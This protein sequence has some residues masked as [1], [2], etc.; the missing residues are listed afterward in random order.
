MFKDELLELLNINKQ[1]IWIKTQLEKEI[2][3][4][5]INVL[6]EYGTDRIFT[7]TPQT[8]IEEIIT[9]DNYYVKNKLAKD[10][11]N[12]PLNYF[13]NQVLENKNAIDFPYEDDYAIIIK[14][15][16]LI[17]ETK[18]H[19]R[20]LKEI[21]EIHQDKYIPLIFTSD[22]Y[23][24]PSKINHLFSVIN[25]QTPTQEEILKLLN[26]YENIKKRTIDNKDV[27]SKKLT[28]F[29]RDEI[30][31]LINLSFYRY[32]RIN[33]DILNDKK[34]ELINKTNVIDY[35]TPKLTLDDIGGNKNFKRWFEEIKLCMDDEATKYGVE[36]PKG[37]LA[38]G[39]AGCSKSALA[40]AIANDLNIP[41][42]KLNMSK[43]LSKF[44][45]DSERRIEQATNLIKSCAPCVLLIDEVEK[46]L[47]GYQS[48]NASDSGT[49]SRVFNKVLDLLVENDNGIF[50]IMTSNN[51]RDLPPELTRAGRLDAIFYFSLPN[52]EE[53]EEIFKIHFKKRNQNISE[54]I[55]KFIAKET[56]N[57]TGAEIEQIVKSSIKKAYANKIKNN[58]EF[59]ITKDI[60]LKA[61]EDVIPISKSSRE[62]IFALEDY[63]NGRAL[64]SNKK[65]K[66]I[67]ID[68]INIDDIE[69]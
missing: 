9:K 40:E 63:A 46:A 16:D 37:Y 14:D 68:S 60:L 1:C 19:I 59:K 41:F 57:Y 8:G 24:P 11:S 52:K 20:I 34:I 33:L 2:M 56:N 47:G 55:I 64:Y 61:K 5:I 42:L 27:V 23:D 17:Y 13:Y 6:I 62:K 39:I 18:E 54:D 65:D 51:V 3:I 21:T 49:L 26:T 53:R 28:G 30:I 48:S 67:D 36:K 25:Y 7:Y 38:L 45:G 50:T 69:I 43:I 15:F 10:I 22:I 31:E 58:E 32:N 66:S 12:R 44:V 35:K 4:N 29:N